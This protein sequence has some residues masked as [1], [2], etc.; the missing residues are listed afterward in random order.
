[1][2]PYFQGSENGHGLADHQVAYGWDGRGSCA[3]LG[4]GLADR[5]AASHIVIDSIAIINRRSSMT[6]DTTSTRRRLP[7]LPRSFVRGFLSGALVVLVAGLGIVLA[8][9]ILASPAPD[10]DWPVV[11][12]AGDLVVFKNRHRLGQVIEVQFSDA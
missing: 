4:D 5:A 9:Q 11:L 2:K 6:I 12:K 10:S 7:P 1:V 8:L 3:G